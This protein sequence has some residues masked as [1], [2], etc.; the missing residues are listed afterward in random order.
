MDSALVGLYLK[1]TLTGQ[2][3]HVGTGSAWEG[4]VPPGSARPQMSKHQNPENI[5]HG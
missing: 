1:T 2:S 4:T 5:R 3:P